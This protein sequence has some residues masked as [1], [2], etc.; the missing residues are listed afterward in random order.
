MLCEYGCGKEA[1]FLTK[2]G[3]NI[4][5]KWYTQCPINK[6]KNSIGVSKAHKEGRLSVEHLRKWKH[7]KGG[8]S[9]N[10]GKTFFDDERIK[11]KIP[12]E[13]IFSKN[14]FFGAKRLRHYLIKYNLISYKCRKC[15]NE[16]IW[17]NEKLV[18]EL[19]HKNG[20]NNDNRLENLEFLCPNCH[21]QSFTFR[22]RNLGKGKTQVSEEEVLKLLKETKNIRQLLIKAGLSAKAGNYARIRNIM[23]KNNVSFSL[24]E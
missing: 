3:K 2:S 16:G 9:W 10:K 11:T 21:S 17:K 1:K 15:E 12:K 8:T 5:E 13:K 20:V 4:C 7:E 24:A 22:A 14:S 19:E 18:L 6:K 23:F